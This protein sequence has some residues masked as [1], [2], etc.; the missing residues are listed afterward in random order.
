M[1]NLRKEYNSNF[2][3]KDNI[4]GLNENHL[5]I[6]G[7]TFAMEEALKIM[8]SSRKK[9][10]NIIIL[11]TK[12]NYLELNNQLNDEKYQD[13]IQ[14]LTNCVEKLK[15]AKVIFNAVGVH[16]LFR[17]LVARRLADEALA[18][19]SDKNKESVTYKNLTKNRKVNKNHKILRVFCEGAI[20]NSKNEH[21]PKKCANIGIGVHL[22]NFNE[23][24]DFSQGL[25]YVDM[26]VNYEQ[27]Q[28]ISAIYGLKQALKVFTEFK[29][30][31]TSVIIY[32]N[33]SNFISTI[34]RKSV[35]DLDFS[36]KPNLIDTKSFLI[37]LNL[38][39]QFEPLKIKWKNRNSKNV[40]KD[41]IEK[42]HKLA[43]GGAIIQEKNN[44]DP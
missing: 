18:V 7:V 44:C 36:P 29:S 25:K 33:S 4:A 2:G 20:I 43:L 8:K 39:K 5:R 27:I 9:Y 13:I 38:L 24:F 3:W 11:L 41:C 42:A 17:L 37:I 21:L 22:P 40:S 6:I 31:H 10:K 1:I 14:N 28:I 16:S 23:K 12:S 26:K 19:S 32:M 15:P 34:S 35:K 30:K